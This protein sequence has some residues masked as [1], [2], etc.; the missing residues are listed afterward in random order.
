MPAR[1]RAA[2]S[3]GRKQRRHC[4]IRAVRLPRLTFPPN[5]PARPSHPGRLYAFRA[6][7]GQPLA[8]SR[9]A[10][11]PADLRTPNPPSGRSRPAH[12]A[13]L[14]RLCPPPRDR[15]WDSFRSP[16]REGS[17]RPAEEVGALLRL[18]AEN[19]KQLLA[20]RTESKRAAKAANQTTVQ[21]LDNNPLKFS[22]TIEDALRIMF[23]RPSRGYLEAHRAMESSFK[24][25]KTHQVKTYAAMQ[26]ALRL[27]MDGLSPEGIEALDEKDHGLGAILS[28]RKARL[29]DIY[30]TR[31]NAIA[32]MHEE[33]MLDAF[34][35]TSRIVTTTAVSPLI[36]RTRDVEVSKT[37]LRGPRAVAQNTQAHTDS[38]S[39]FGMPP[40]RFP[41][42]N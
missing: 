14:G 20:A 40:N 28:S 5:R 16:G 35:I 1:R 27:L 11:T 18:N 22:P 9:S 39:G 29:W 6:A 15:A 8:S 33:G 2:R 24:D 41:G 26:N 23:G 13:K 36:S 42:S 7:A 31:W 10:P 30:T 4:R 19:V 17:R 32:S 37:F 38:H 3:S 21:A 25:L 34:M 12:P